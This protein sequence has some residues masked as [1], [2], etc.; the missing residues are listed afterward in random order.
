MSMCVAPPLT[1]M[2][3]RWRGTY[4][5]WKAAFEGAAQPW[6]EVTEETGRPTTDYEPKDGLSATPPFMLRHGPLAYM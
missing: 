2:S 5:R 4:A 6:V 3:F 1:Y